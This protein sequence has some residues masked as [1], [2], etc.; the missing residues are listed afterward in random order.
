[1]TTK[2]IKHTTL[3]IIS[4]LITISCGKENSSNS[5]LAPKS[6]IEMASEEANLKLFSEAIRLA[7][8][9]Y[10]MNPGAKY[11]LMAPT[12]DSFSI[13]LKS[14]GL[15]SVAELRNYYGKTEFNLFVRYHILESLITSD[16]IFSGYVTTF[17]ELN[18]NDRL[19]SYMSRNGLEIHINGNAAEVVEPEIIGTGGAIHKIDGVLTPLTLK[20]L[21]SVNPRFSKLTDVIRYTEPLV[22]SAL[23]GRHKAHTLFAPTDAAF[24]LF[25]NF[26]GYSDLN[27]LYSFVTK[28]QMADALKY[29][30]VEGRFNAEDFQN[31]AYETLL[32]GGSLNISKDVSGTII[33]SDDK[34]SALVKIISTNIVGINGVMHTIDKVLEYQ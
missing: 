28:E 18:D 23:D 34:G 16:D 32:S 11:T 17:A 10:F 8:V 19:H 31:S 20:G 33:I 22:D 24:N 5:S 12:D 27:T 3:L 29:H 4:I 21:V 14:L 2:F 30:L 15:T 25:L 6:V 1:M 9:E 13:F 26:Y 7:E